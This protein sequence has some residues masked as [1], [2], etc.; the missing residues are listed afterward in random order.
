MGQM[1]DPI[2]EARRRMSRMEPTAAR[3]AMASYVDRLT[4]DMANSEVLGEIMLQA[5]RKLPPE[6]LIS[7][8]TDRR[9]AR[10]LASLIWELPVSDPHWPE[11][12]DRLSY[13]LPRAS[14]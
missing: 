8:K 6:G 5:L 14:L 10:A 7:A 2:Q 4:A 12:L 3:L 11:I 13:A 1:E 9:A